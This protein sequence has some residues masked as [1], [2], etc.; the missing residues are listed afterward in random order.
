L[1]QE[2]RS[3]PAQAALLINTQDELAEVCTQFAAAHARFVAHGIHSSPVVTAAA[4]LTALDTSGLDW[5]SVGV[6]AN[7]RKACISLGLL[8]G[9]AHVVFAHPHV[10]ERIP[11]SAAYYLAL[12]GLGGKAARRI[13]PS[14]ARLAAQVASGGNSAGL[15]SV[16]DAALVNR[17]VSEIIRLPGFTLDQ[18]RLLPLLSVGATLDG[19]WKDRVGRIGALTVACMMAHLLHEHVQKVGAGPNE[20]PVGY[21]VHEVAYMTPASQLPYSEAVP[22]TIVLANDVRIEFARRYSTDPDLIVRA[23]DG[24]WLAAGEV[25]GGTDPQSAWERLSL[26]L[27]TITDIRN[28]GY[29]AHTMLFGL[30]LTRSSVMGTKTRQ[31]ILHYLTSPNPATPFLN[32]AFNIWRLRASEAERERLRVTLLQVC[33]LL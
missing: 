24:E 15:L 6:L 17:Q 28:S 27:R 8:D 23:P 9:Q 4:A 1:P 7:D 25:K 21:D 13:V 5:Q 3:D 32:S 33:G 30:T 14:L 20:N 31:G 19:A 18:L 22:S 2:N 29:R 12:S 10:V 11:G 16:K 26:A